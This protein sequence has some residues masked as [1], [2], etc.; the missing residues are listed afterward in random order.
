MCGLADQYYH[1]YLEGQMICRQMLQLP[2][3]LCHTMKI[4]EYVLDNCICGIIRF[5]NPARL[6][7]WAAHNQCNNLMQLL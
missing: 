3:N 5:H 1:A 4:F 2:S 7:Q 6:R